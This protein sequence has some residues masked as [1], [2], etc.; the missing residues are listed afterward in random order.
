M[1]IKDELRQL[2]RLVRTNSFRFLDNDLLVPGTEMVE[3]LGSPLAL[4]GA[5]SLALTMLMMHKY[6][7]RLLTLAGPAPDG[8]TW[9]DKQYLIALSM[10]VTGFAYVISWDG[11]FPDRRDSMVLCSLPIPMR[12]LFSAKVI[13]ILGLLFLVVL[14]ANLVSSVAFPS[15]MLFAE[16]GAPGLV[17]YIFIHSGVMFAASTFLFFSLLALEGIL[18]NMLSYSTFQRLSCYFQLGLLFLFLFVFILIPKADP[19]MLTDPKNEALIRWLPPYWFLG[20][21]QSWLGDTQPVVQRWASSA[22]FATLASGLL[23]AV[24]YSLG[25]RNAVR[26]AL[27]QSDVIPAHHRRRN[28]ALWRLADR[29]L[30]RSPAG[31]AVFHFV[32][33]TIFRNKRNRLMLAGYLSAGVG[34]VLADVALAFHRGGKALWSPTAALASVPIVVTLLLLVGL[35]VLFS[36]P[37]ELKANWIFRMTGSGRFEEYRFAV[38]MVMFLVG[39][40]PV[41]A[42]SLPAYGYL[43]GWKAAAAHVVVVVLVALSSIELLLNDFPKLPFTCS[44]L[45]GKASLK[46]T[47]ACYALAFSATTTL[48]SNIEAVLLRDPEICLY[49]CL[50]GLA[51]LAFLI[52]QRKEDERVPQDFI[53]EE[54]DTTVQTL[55]LQT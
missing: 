42:A 50:P 46:T 15:F 25:Y 38:R 47:F 28:A 43:W 24:M 5:L 22:S 27:E 51:F 48:I 10:L 7:F 23:A 14:A 9:P 30:L 55:G 36:M 35:R 53:Y 19:F 1:D 41:A 18:I 40:L 29:A 44:Y 31:R 49:F 17:R 8:Y 33:R 6:V 21:Y 39:V 54:R 34:Y 16:Q 45:P 2:G 3:T 20:L 32:A 37:V 4:L 13:S 52:S 12:T 11:L 26:K